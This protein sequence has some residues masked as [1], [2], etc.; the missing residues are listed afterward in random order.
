M[1]FLFHI[2]AHFKSE[3]LLVSVLTDLVSGTNSG[4]AVPREGA[5]TIFG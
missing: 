3:L 4:L 5:K 1:E 2:S